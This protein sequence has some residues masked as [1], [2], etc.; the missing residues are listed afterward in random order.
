MLGD[1]SGARVLDLYAGTGALGIEALS[2]GAQ[3]SVFVEERRAALDALKKNLSALGLEEVSSVI[4]LAVE[5]ASSALAP[6]APFDLVLCDPP[7]SDLAAAVRAL[8]ELCPIL[9]LGPGARVVIEHSET[10]EPDPDPKS[11]LRSA[12][13]RVWGDTAVSVFTVET[14]GNVLSNLFAQFA[15]PS[16][17]LASLSA[18]VRSLGCLILRSRRP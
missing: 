11:G 5:R 17:I 18:V 1:L 10:D 2:R 12:T 9:G 15:F 8:G 3:F 14:S 7:W 4:P 13:R 16:T 6:H